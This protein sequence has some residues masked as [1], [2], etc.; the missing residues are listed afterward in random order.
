MHLRS[1]ER[2]PFDAVLLPFSFAGLQDPAYRADVEALLAVC[3][4]RQVAVQTIKAVARRRWPADHEG[5]RYSWYEPL[6]RGRRPSVGPC[7]GC[8]ATRSCS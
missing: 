8:S 4:E 3:A 2:F 6:P 7:A 5:P 1:L